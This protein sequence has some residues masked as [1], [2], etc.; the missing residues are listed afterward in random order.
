MPID[1]SR[2]RTHESSTPPRRH[3]L[4]G[5]ALAA[6]LAATFAASTPARACGMETFYMGPPPSAEKL[7]AQAA[8]ALREDRSGS[9]GLRARQVIALRRARPEQRAAAWTILA[10]TQLKR[11]DRAQALRSLANGQALNVGAVSTVLAVAPVDPTMQALRAAK[12]V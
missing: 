2:K 3:A 9:A 4:L 6:A 11:G 5:L 1:S 10:W 8:R 7:L 12:R